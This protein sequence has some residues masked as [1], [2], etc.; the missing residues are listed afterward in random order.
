MQAWA[1][2]VRARREGRARLGA[3]AAAQLLAGTGTRPSGQARL[4]GRGAALQL[5]ALAGWRQ[6][7]EAR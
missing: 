3:L 1:E 2:A 6:H 4:P 5:A 7:V